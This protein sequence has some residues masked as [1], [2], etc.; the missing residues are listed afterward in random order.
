VLIE[1]ELETSGVAH[2][3]AVVERLGVLLG[4]AQEAGEISDAVLAGTP[5]QARELWALRE[6]ISESL[7]RH[8]PHK[9]DVALPVSRVAEFAEACRARAA[10]ELPEAEVVI[11]GHVG[12]GNLHLNLLPAEG[13]PSPE[14]T[15][16]CR[17]FDARTYGL[18][19]SMHGSISAEHGIG[20]LKREHLAH[21]KSPVAIAMMRAIKQA[22]DPDGLLNPG[23]IFV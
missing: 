12:D 18:V 5:A 22:L 13:S 2:E 4:D 3:E 8:G 23:K 9:S 10:A 19:E 15:A 21:S 6:D 14:F 16:R 17:H 1:T 11:F 20:L 7:H